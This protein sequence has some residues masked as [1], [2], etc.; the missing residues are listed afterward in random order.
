MLWTQVLYI[1]IVTVSGAW[2]YFALQYSGRSVGLRNVIWLL[3]EPA[4]VLIFVWNDALHS[5]YWHRIEIVQEGGFSVIALTQG[6]GLWLHATYSYI[7][8]LISLVVLVR[9]YLRAHGPYRKQIGALIAASTVPWLANFIYLFSLSPF[10]FLDLTPF[11]FAFTGAIS[12]WALFR[13]RL[14]DLTP[15]ARDL[16]IEHM[17]YGVLVLDDKGDIIDVNP[18]ARNLFVLE[19]EL[20][21][22]GID[23]VSTE[24][25]NWLEGGVSEVQRTELM[26]GASGHICEVALFPLES[27]GGESRGHLLMLQDISERKRLEAGDSVSRQMREDIWGMER[28]EDIDKVLQH[29]YAMLQALGV[30]FAY[31]GLNIFDPNS[32]SLKYSSYELDAG[33]QRVGEHITYEHSNELISGVWRSGQPLYR[34]DLHNDDAYGERA[35]IDEMFAAEIRCVIDVP[36]SHGTLAANSTQVDAFPAVAVESIKLVA[37]LLS[38][39]FRRCDDIRAS[40]R[41]LAELQHEVDEHRRTA[42]EL[43]IAKD[44]AESATEAKSKFLAN[45][46]HEIRTPM[47]AVLGMTELLLETKLNDEQREHLQL[48]YSSAGNLL[49]LLNDLLEFSRAEHH[50]VRLED[51]P[52]LLREC[53]EQAVA[54]V[55]PLAQSKS[56][57]V[58]WNTDDSVAELYK[59]DAGRLSQILINLA[60]NAI[61]F[62]NEGT[63]AVEVAVE[64]SR[65]GE[66]VL[67]FAVVDTG[68]GIEEDM[69]GEVFGAFTQADASTTRQFGGTGLGLAISKHL[70]ELMDGTIWVE[71]QFGQGST[72]LFTVRLG[73]VGPEMVELAEPAV[74]KPSVARPA[75]QQSAQR[76]LLVED[77]ESN[78]RVVQSMLGRCGHEVV[79]MSSGSAALVHLQQDR[80]FDL[81]LMDLQM[82]GMSG[83]ETTEVIR[84]QERENKYP[85][86]KIVALTG[87]ALAG[88]REACLAAGMDDYL[89]K[90]FRSAELLALIETVQEAGGE[91]EVARASLLEGVDGDEELLR[92]LVGLILE[93]RIR[94]QGKIREAVESGDAEELIGTVHVY[95]GVLGVLGEN[96]AFRAAAELEQC[97]RTGDVGDAAG[98]FEKLIEAVEQHERVL[99]EVIR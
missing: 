51:E 1:G 21:G 32:A 75:L 14:F 53:V 8:L 73:W 26:L 95:K 34:P 76:V 7:L 74:P 69:V 79:I 94:S 59:G 9:C 71:S 24:I 50:A 61:K 52:F 10:P 15:V 44:A 63:V 4:L 30:P 54:T 22:L 93:A 68:V 98:L 3:V 20:V 13:F 80:A 83:Y 89:A 64:E 78:Q 90:P 18:A 99:R 31:C 11:A 16:L 49:K 38:E 96:G 36:F 91:L 48:V 65:E 19:K 47:N 5:L 56:L 55:K 57:S 33:G 12:V 42:E 46:S 88:D 39:A 72:F 17:S 35:V 27:A 40:E 82:P 86:L 97:A 67:R 92:E 29:S 70:V 60:G 2:F 77:M 87:N 28:G 23:E 43:L 84:E 41:H 85:A 25:A 62:T 6:L 58:S 45:M 66:D 37:D 81:V